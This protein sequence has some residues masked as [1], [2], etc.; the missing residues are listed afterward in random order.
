MNENTATVIDKAR[1]MIREIDDPVELKRQLEEMLTEACPVP[2]QRVFDPAERMLMHQFLERFQT[3]Y[4]KRNV[5]AFYHWP[6]TIDYNVDGDL[7]IQ[8]EGSRI[9]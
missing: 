1:R 7:V 4:C 2:T 3:S 6:V 9:A 8:F 5:P